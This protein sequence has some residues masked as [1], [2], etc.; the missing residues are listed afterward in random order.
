MFW[1]FHFIIQIKEC[2]PDQSQHENQGINRTVIRPLPTY[3]VHVIDHT[4]VHV[5]NI[6]KPYYNT[7]C[8]RKYF[9]RVRNKIEHT[10]NTNKEISE[11]EAVF[12][13]IA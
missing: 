2:E 11:D 6:I 5:T 8:H 13:T 9:T 12:Y 4:I 1:A 7:V 3:V 10:A